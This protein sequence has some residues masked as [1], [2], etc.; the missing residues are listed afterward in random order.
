MFSF[1]TL[2]LRRSR[3][4]FTERLSQHAVVIG[5]TSLPCAGRFD[6]PPKSEAS[7]EASI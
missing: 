6:G 1:T 7:I 5:F 4:G 2:R 3:L